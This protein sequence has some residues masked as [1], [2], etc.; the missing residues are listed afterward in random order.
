MTSHWKTYQRQK[1][2]YAIE[3]YLF[4]NVDYKA[5]K[6]TKEMKFDFWRQSYQTG[7]NKVK[8]IVRNKIRNELK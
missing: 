7:K 5:S 6:K 1:K 8:N 3:S 4:I 2:E